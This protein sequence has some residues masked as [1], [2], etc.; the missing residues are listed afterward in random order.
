MSIYPYT[1]SALETIA[2]KTILEYDPYLLVNPAPIP[3]EDIMEKL[4][5]LT[6]EFQY[7][8]NNGRVLGETVFEDGMLPIYERKNNEGYKLIPVKAG[9]VLIDV[10]LLN[11]QSSGRFRWTCGH[12]LFHWIAHK[13]HYTGTGE[14]AAM[15]TA[16]RG[17]STDKALE[18]QADRFCGYL[19]MPKGMVKKAY[20]R[21]HQQTN[22]KISALA[23]L[24]AV[25]R[26]AMEIRLTDMR[27]LM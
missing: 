7:I 17:S 1:V 22:E 18:R 15:T 25:S 27:L 3:V 24:F 26:Q 21:I 23:N 16:A 11:C 4:Y 12:E 19:L 5:G 9:T 8:R 14:V 6:I 2:R 13:E 20:Y 10:S